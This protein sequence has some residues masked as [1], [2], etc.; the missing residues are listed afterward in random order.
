EWKAFNKLPK[1]LQSLSEF[2][3][4]KIKKIYGFHDELLAERN[5]FLSAVSAEPQGN[6]SLNFFLEDIASNFSSEDCPESLRS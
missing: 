3:S 2:I 1:D 4:R 6:S 5:H